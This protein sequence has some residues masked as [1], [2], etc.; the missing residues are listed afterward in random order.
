MLAWKC[1]IYANIVS[2]FFKAWVSYWDWFPAGSGLAR[3][4]NEEEEERPSFSESAFCWFDIFSNSWPKHIH[5]SCT[6]LVKCIQVRDFHHDLS[7]LHLMWWKC[8]MILILR[9]QVY[10]TNWVATLP[11]LLLLPWLCLL[12]W[13]LIG[14]MLAVAKINFIILIKSCR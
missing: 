6:V 13:I 3:S 2:W 10:F 7:P 1:K 12:A 14:F 8:M 9:L 4:G 11:S 5:V